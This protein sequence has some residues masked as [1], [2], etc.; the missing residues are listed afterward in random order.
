M[1]DRIE[2]MLLESRVEDAIVTDLRL[3]AEEGLTN[4][5]VHA[6]GIGNEGD[7][8]VT[9]SVSTSSVR[10]V[11]RD[12]ARP[13][14]PL[15]SPRPDIDAPIDERPIGGLGIH[16]IRSLTD[17]QSYERD[18]EENVLVLIKHR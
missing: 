10:F 14:N 4:V 1:L 7:I 12:R 8:E 9:L 5:I 3:V 16:L 13:F 11:L 2:G 18:G 17:E 6:Y 15:E